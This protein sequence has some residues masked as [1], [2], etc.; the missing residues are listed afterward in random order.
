MEIPGD[1]TLF[2]RHAQSRHSCVAAYE[3]WPWPPTWRPSSVD[4]TSLWSVCTFTV[5][6][7][8]WTI[9]PS[10]TLKTRSL[11]SGLRTSDSW[12]CF[13][14]YTV[15]CK[16]SKSVHNAFNGFFQQSLWILEN[17]GYVDCAYEL[18][19]SMYTIGVF[20][21]NKIRDKLWV[22][23]DKLWVVWDKLWVVW[24]KLW[25]V[26]SRRIYLFVSQIKR[27]SCRIETE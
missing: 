9:L 10:R 14:M 1:F 5:W 23:W 15:R 26:R 2:L 21:W 19:G 25:V 16:Y 17:L 8:L 18:T 24:D 22:V 12:A 20:G 11:M 13:L 27:I 6:S 4:W 3:T 7:L